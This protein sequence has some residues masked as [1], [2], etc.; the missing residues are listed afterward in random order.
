V[1]IYEEHGRFQVRWDGKR[2]TKVIRVGAA[3]VEVGTIGREHW[4]KPSWER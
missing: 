1:A 4:G 2:R 3:K